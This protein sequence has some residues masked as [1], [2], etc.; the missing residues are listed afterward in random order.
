MYE[1]YIVIIGGRVGFLQVHVGINT[2]EP[3]DKDQVQFTS[4]YLYREVPFVQYAFSF[5]I[6]FID[7]HV[8]VTEMRVT[9]IAVPGKGRY[10][11]HVVGLE[12]MDTGR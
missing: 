1:C 5:L 9:D 10:E 6:L 8:V 11:I 3:F 2:A 12:C 7:V 4:G